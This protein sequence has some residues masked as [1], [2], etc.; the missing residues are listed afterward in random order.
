[1][2]FKTK[3]LAHQLRALEHHN[4]EFLAL[5]MEQGTGKTKVTI[6]TAGLLHREGLLDTVVVA[7]PGGVHLNWADIEIPKHCWRD[8]R[9]IVWASDLSA[10][11]KKAIMEELR[12][13]ADGRLVWF[14]TNIEAL[15]TD[16]GAI[17]TG[18]ALKRGKSM[19]V[20]DESVTIKNPTAQQTK[21]AIALGSLAKYRRILTGTPIAKSPLDLFSQFKFLH[22]EALPY[23]SMTAFKADFAIQKTE[24]MG[25]RC[26]ERIVGYKN[27]S[28]LTALITPHSF[29]VMK[30]E[31][32]DLPPKVYQ[33]QVV[34][35]PAEMR[36]SYRKLRQECMLELESAEAQHLV[37]A[38]TVV[39]QMTK[40]RQ[41]LAGF[42]VDTDKVTHAMPWNPKL[43][44]LIEMVDSTIQGKVII[45]TV[46]KFT[47][48]EIERRLMQE[49]GPDCAVSYYGETSDV[50]RAEA[51]R[52][53]MEDPKC[54]FFI[55]NKTA[56]RGLTLT[57]AQTAIYFDNDMS[58]EVRQQSEDRTHRHGQTGTCVYID[59]VFPRTMDDRVAT[60]LHDKRQ[61][62]E[63]VLIKNWRDL[64]SDDATDLSSTNE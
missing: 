27:L 42:L 38:T 62:S 56:A 61:L 63:E 64:F 5:F 40:L 35:M 21:A 36:A 22:K 17:A 25:Q 13:P 60:I 26:I 32:L 53:F 43:D 7:T 28:M 33:R 15:R 11:R 30:S 54:R 39:A 57:A 10:K 19:M 48:K 20:I 34:E 46:F 45:W 24:K 44:T 52:R 14:L 16:A 47:I 12:K 4:R 9:V 1:M 50:G 37:T 18:T 29:R 41:L 2:S 55:A 49:F 31:C 23:R 58:L 51:V 8:S 59:F 3:P 6:D